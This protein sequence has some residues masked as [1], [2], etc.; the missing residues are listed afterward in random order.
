MYERKS[1]DPRDRTGIYKHPSNVPSEYLL[2]E[3]EGGYQGRNV[4]REWAETTTEQHESARYQQYL[5]RAERHWKDHMEE[6]GRHHALATP[7]D[8]EEWAESV[9]NR[10]QP[11]SAYQIYYVRVEQFYTW[12]LYHTDHPHL[13]HPVWMAADDGATSVIWDMKMERRA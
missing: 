13:Y 9:L 12:L 11:L 5:E 2:E 3:Y 4:W 6:R 7:D 8:V 10:C 1:T